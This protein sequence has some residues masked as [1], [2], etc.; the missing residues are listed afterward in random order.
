MTIDYD[1]IGS[2][3]EPARDP[4]SLL[5]M[6]SSRPELAVLV[7]VVQYECFENSIRNL[8]GFA[9][10]ADSLQF[11]NVTKLKV[12][13]YT[14]ETEA[15]LPMLLSAWRQ[16]DYLSIL[17]SG[18]SKAYDGNL[19][20]RSRALYP[21]TLRLKSLDV[22]AGNVRILLDV[23][24]HI[25]LTSTRATLQYVTLMY[26]QHVED[27]GET[28][29]NAHP[30]LYTPFSSLI[31]NLSQFRNLEMLKF[32]MKSNTSSWS[33]DTSGTARTFQLI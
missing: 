10:Q 15:E 2:D 27:D 20:P 31:L 14:H 8:Q 1:Y 7:R 17:A 30:Q 28:W 29:R 12:Y 5:A 22:G 32:T 26:D 18:R 24:H 9:T 19:R 25:L 23:V 3:G 4:G 21:S 33:S 13:G 16:L 11:L 6:I